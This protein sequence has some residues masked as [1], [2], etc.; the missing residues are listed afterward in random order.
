MHIFSLPPKYVFNDRERLGN[1]RGQGMKAYPQK[2]RP[3]TGFSMIEVI[4]VLL[5]ISIVGAVVASR[6]VDTGSNAAGEA[7][8]LKANL[9]FA[10]GRALSE[11]PQ[12]SWGLL[13][14][15]AS[16]TLI[17]NGLQASSLPGE[18]SAVHV[19]EGVTITSGTGTLTFDFRCQPYLGGSLLAAN[20]V[21]TFS[22]GKAV[23][24][25]S[26]TGFIP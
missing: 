14:T 5:L 25:T 4:A 15:S 16:Y 9:R 13:I 10:Q 18:N 2:N 23:T 8:L 1:G 3:V 17:K 26:G 11:G 20:H 21:I 24:I 22:G 7:E 12:V 19:L 6:L